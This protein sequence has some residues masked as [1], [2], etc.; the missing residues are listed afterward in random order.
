[1]RSTFSASLCFQ[2]LHG[3]SRVDEAQNLRDDTFEN[4]RLLSNYETDG[5]KLLQ[6]I[7]S[8]QPELGSKAR[9]AIPPP[10]KRARGSVLLPRPA[11]T[12]RSQAFHRAPSRPTRRFLDL[13]TPQC[14]APQPTAGVKTISYP[15]PF[16]RHPVMCSASSQL[17][18]KGVEVSSVMRIIVSAA[19][20]SPVARGFRPFLP[21]AGLTVHDLLCASFR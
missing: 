11:P 12:T 18:R 21:H 7:L 13:F 3:R 4:I 20:R 15:L 5:D 6:I 1:M 2:R 16:H 19:H 17:A 9:R 10:A 14:V 8:G